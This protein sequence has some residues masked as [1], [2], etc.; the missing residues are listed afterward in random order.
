MT[1][2][3]GRNIENIINDEEY[4]EFVLDEPW[5]E[6]TIGSSELCDLRI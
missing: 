5:K 2:R 6:Y 4:L 3:I 1:I